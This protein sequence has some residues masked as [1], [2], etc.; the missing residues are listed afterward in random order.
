M[1]STP[2]TQ[3]TTPTK[4]IVAM[5]SICT[6]PL[7]F[8]KP[9][10]ELTDVTAYAS[11]SA[12]HDL[13]FEPEIRKR[14][15]FDAHL[16]AKARTAYRDGLI[17]SSELVIQALEAALSDGDSA[18]ALVEIRTK[19]QRKADAEAHSQLK[20]ANTAKAS[21]FGTRASFRA[22]AALR[23][24]DSYDRAYARWLRHVR[25]A[26]RRAHGKHDHSACHPASSDEE[27]VGTHIVD[28]RAET[29]PDPMEAIATEL[30]DAIHR[31][32]TGLYP[33]PE[34]WAEV[35]GPP[36]VEEDAA[37]VEAPATAPPAAAA[38]LDPTTAVSEPPPISG[39]VDVLQ[40][41][42]AT[43]GIPAGPLSESLALGMHPEKIGAT[44]LVISDDTL[45][46]KLLGLRCR[47]ASSDIASSSNEESSD[48]EEEATHAVDLC[49][50]GAQ[51]AF[52]DVLATFR[53]AEPQ[54]A[55]LG[56]DENFSCDAAGALAMLAADEEEF[57]DEHRFSIASDFDEH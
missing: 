57:E 52:D 13:A 53:D 8:S 1:H 37:A 15:E 51:A 24:L 35:H 41:M 28:L 7:T 5:K 4:T 54:L 40:L 21:S 23:E 38:V 12:G 34:A 46:W 10:M 14:C 45:A 9:S 33:Q 43:S 44:D 18:T 27:D 39:D 49:V 19:A 56:E 31:I 36:A 16:K 11:R 22:R 2:S 26:T 50:H 42:A 30:R 6:T 17:R 3:Y 32:D 47:R 25:A 48:E 55:A 20:H 29:G